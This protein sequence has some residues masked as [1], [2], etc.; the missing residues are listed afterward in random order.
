M[1]FDKVIDNIKDDWAKQSLEFYK[2]WFRQAQ[3]WDKTKEKWEKRKKAYSHPPLKKSGKMFTN[4][5]SKVT[6]DNVLIYN[7]TPYSGFHNE[8]TD[9]IPQRQFIGESDELNSRLL[10]IADKQI[11][12]FFMELGDEFENDINKK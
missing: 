10:K 2:Y 12:Q 3:F 8:G 5:K 4:I 1:K 9:K 6:G 11:E 7:N